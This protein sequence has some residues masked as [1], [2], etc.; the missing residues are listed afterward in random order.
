MP[1]TTSPMP[2]RSTVIVASLATVMLVAGV[3]VTRFTGNDSPSGHP[4][5]PQAAEPTPRPPVAGGSGQP[6]GRPARETG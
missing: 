1:S 2:K 3:A 5:D 4:T 6:L